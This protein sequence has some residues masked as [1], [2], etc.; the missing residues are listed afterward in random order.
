[1]RLILKA[2]DPKTGRNAL[3]FE[4]KCGQLVWDDREDGK[5]DSGVD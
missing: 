3:A 5:K 1:M 2:V 4:C